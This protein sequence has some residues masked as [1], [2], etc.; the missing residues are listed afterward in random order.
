MKSKVH[1]SKY[2]TVV[3]I[4]VLAAF[5]VGLFETYGDQRS[6]AL[7]SIMTLL[8]VFAGLYYCPKAVSAGESG[9][10]IHR[11]LSGDK[12]FKYSDIREVDTC[13]PS[14]GGIRLCGSGGFFGYWGYFSDILVGQY[15]GYYAD[16]DQCFYIKL[17]NNRQYVI[18]CNNHTEIVNEIRKHIV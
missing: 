1:F 11:L 13:Y 15:F 7:L 3:T 10:R 6:F 17:Q 14:A 18:S 9:L 16:R 2:C 12:I 4:L 5:I 8:A